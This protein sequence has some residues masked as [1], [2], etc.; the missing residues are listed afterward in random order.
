MAT[1]RERF[2]FQNTDSS[3]FLLSLSEI[4]KKLLFLN[5]GALAGTGKNE[6]TCQTLKIP[7]I[8]GDH[9]KLSPRLKSP[10]RDGQLPIRLLTK[11]VWSR[12][13]FS[14]RRADAIFTRRE[15]SVALFSAGET[16]AEKGVCSPQAKVICENFNRVYATCLSV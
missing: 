6:N 2:T 14:L 5:S 9:S 16:K 10:M 1:A 15:K 13:N 4:L 7:L 3:R 8:A 12:G 11:S